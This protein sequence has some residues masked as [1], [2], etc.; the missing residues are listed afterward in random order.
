MDTT[1]LSEPKKELQNLPGHETRYLKSLLPLTP[2]TG[3]LLFPDTRHL[4]PET[5]SVGA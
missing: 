3:N 1:V 5:Y 2:D 4:A